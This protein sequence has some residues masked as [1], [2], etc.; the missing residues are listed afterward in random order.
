MRSN[1]KR[2][3]CN[4]KNIVSDSSLTNRDRSK[5][6]G[7]PEVY[8]QRKKHREIERLKERLQRSWNTFQIHQKCYH[9][10]KK[11]HLLFCARQLKNS[12]F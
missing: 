11:L 3:F 4:K 9:E 1:K 6:E 8:L 7:L 5:S 12:T 2:G 10:L